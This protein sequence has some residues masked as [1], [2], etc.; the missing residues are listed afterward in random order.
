[1][2]PV[3]FAFNST[4]KPFLISM[5]VM[6]TIFSTAAVAGDNVYSLVIKDHRFQPSE[7]TV[8]A[9]KKIKL[10]VENQDPT[11]EEFESHD[12][13]REKVIAGNSTA[14]IF[15]GPLAPGRYRFFGEFNEKTAQGVIVAQ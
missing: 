5:C 3:K 9:G 4:R 10:S 11:A 12:L 14:T 13:N 1:M 2:N 8:P 6:T 15:V 7:L